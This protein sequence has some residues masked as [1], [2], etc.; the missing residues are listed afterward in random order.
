MLL[1]SSFLSCWGPQGW[2]ERS[3]EEEGRVLYRPGRLVKVTV[4][5]SPP[6]T[7]GLGLL[8]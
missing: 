4:V 2:R 1:L 5:F 8:F 6:K 7:G 3:E